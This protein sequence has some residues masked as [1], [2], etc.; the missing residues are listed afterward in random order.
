VTDGSGSGSG[1]VGG[2]VDGSGLGVVVVL[3][4]DGVA[5]GDGDAEDGDTEGF[6]DGFRDWGTLLVGRVLGVLEGSATSL[7][8]GGSVVSR[9]SCCF[10]GLLLGCSSS[11]PNAKI[12]PRPPATANSA[13]MANIRTRWVPVW[14]LRAGTG[15]GGGAL[16]GTG[17]ARGAAG[18]S[19]TVG[20]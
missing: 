17:T 6:A 10:P 15:T 3:V 19:G 2:V 20:N 5:L 14:P 7:T 1:S 8:A 9:T 4:C 11:E 16:R 12:T 18:L 13:R